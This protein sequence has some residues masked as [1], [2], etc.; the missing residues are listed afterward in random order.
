M[1]ALL[2]EERMLTEFDHARLSRLIRPDS[3]GAS[4]PTTP[5]DALLDGAEVVPWHEVPADVVTMHT[6]VLL[7][8][9]AT[10]KGR[11]VTLCYPDG[12][13]PTAGFV[14]VL[15]PVGSSLLGLR[16][17]S[18]ATWRTPDGGEGTARIGEILFQPEACAVNNGKEARK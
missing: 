17:G 9:P 2:L 13:D 6:R 16:S 7:I 3:R 8:D 5:L 4:A 10:A 14:S 15:S 12:A 11:A 18:I 1:Q